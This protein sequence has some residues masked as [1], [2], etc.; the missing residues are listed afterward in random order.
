MSEK[1]K[2]GKHTVELTHPDKVF[3]PD[4]N[5]T[6]EDLVNYFNDIADVM[7]PYLED[8]PL[9]MLRYPDGIKGESFFHKDAP[10]YFPSWIKTRSVKKEGGGTVNHVICNNAAALVYVANQGC[11]T[12]H[13]W[14]SRTDRL[15]K[16]DTL[17]FD[18]DPPGDNFGEVIF[19][20]RELRKLITDELGITTF[21]KTTG[22]KG[23]HIEIPLQRKE[24]FDEVREFGQ[25]AAKILAGRHPDRLTTEVRKNK[26]KGR[27][28]IDVARNAYAQTAAAPYAVRA[29]PGAPVAAPI[30][31][32]EL[33]SRMSPQKYN[34]KNIFRRLS[35]KE[36]PWKDFARHA[37]T[38][39][40]ESK[41]AEEILKAM[42]NKKE[43]E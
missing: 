4:D 6:K 13:T 9:V 5:Y 31:W 20:A 3:F 36:D 12:P 28:F 2:I 16:P 37:V 25:T 30:G 14:L 17:I 24:N 18:L 29:L 15:H 35:Q 42:K 32:D 27:V 1:L 11:V 43:G 10:D 21:I 19:A 40:K 26:R 7:V 8:R 23:V 39:K 38:I 34:I 41:K 22:S 33:N